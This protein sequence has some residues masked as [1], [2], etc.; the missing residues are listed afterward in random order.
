MRAEV[1]TRNRRPGAFV[2]LPILVDSF[3]RPALPRTLAIVLG[4]LC[5]LS[6]SGA[7]LTRIG[8]SLGEALLTLAHPGQHDNGNERGG[9]GES[10]RERNERGCHCGFQDCLPAY[11]ECEPGGTRAGN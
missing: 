1:R 8:M 2:H 9:D 10:D 3:P 5:S 11:S 6:R 7:Q 4:A